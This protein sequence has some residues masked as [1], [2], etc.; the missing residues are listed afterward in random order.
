MRYDDEEFEAFYRRNYASV[1]WFFIRAR[2]A[3]D[4]AHELAQ[5][6]FLRAWK[7]RGE[8]RKESEKS[9]LHKIALRVLLDRNRRLRTQRRHVQYESTDDPAIE[10]KLVEETPDVETLM[11]RRLLRD[12]IRRL[13]PITRE[14]I[15]YRIDGYT[16]EEIARLV[17]I[18]VESVRTRLRD[19][20]EMLKE[21]YD[22][23]QK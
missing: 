13:P 10:A 7:A 23:Q 8:Y 1:Y 21:D 22:D 18:S 11:Q 9:Y 15:L 3:D 6:V 4:E 2:I 19:A 12:M 20:K 16:Y 17:Q 5:E 14:C